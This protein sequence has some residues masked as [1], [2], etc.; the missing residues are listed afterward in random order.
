MVAISVFAQRLAVAQSTASIF[1]AGNV[2]NWGDPSI[3]KAVHQV[4]RAR[5]FQRGN[6]SAR[7]M[8]VQQASMEGHLD[9]A[10]LERDR[11]VRDLRFAATQNLT[12]VVGDFLSTHP[13]PNTV[14]EM[15]AQLPSFPFE[16][17]GRIEDLERVE[18]IAEMQAAPQTA[19]PD[20]LVFRA[21]DALFKRKVLLKVPKERFDRS[22]LTVDPPN[23]MS[24]LREAQILG[25]TN[26]DLL[27]FISPFLGV[28][29]MDPQSEGFREL[30]GSQGTVVT[31]SG[32]LEGRTFSDVYSMYPEPLPSIA[33]ILS[34]FVALANVVED[35]HKA[36][37]LHGRLLPQHVL[38]QE[39]GGK[40]DRIALLNL[41]QAMVIAPK[42]REGLFWEILYSKHDKSLLAPEV[43]YWDPRT[44]PRITFATDVYSLGAMLALMTPGLY[45]QQGPKVE[46]LGRPNPE[47]R[48]L[49]EA[50]TPIVL[51]ATQNNPEDRYPTAAAM[52]EDL[53]RLQ[54]RT[55]SGGIPQ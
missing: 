12:A 33:T 53:V 25:H 7:S 49:L 17:F 29:Y 34:W 42:T 39:L 45:L 27:P 31:V 28:Y 16:R 19:D 4:E 1:A 37:F 14:R 36:G 6:M 8:A 35:L 21:T 20:T 30:F 26:V 32:L 5:L 40:E 22:S 44:Q 15:I 50:I 46:I 43:I 9:A 51:R 47:E 10:R 48:S 55:S 52:R 3:D 41:E 23:P 2:G 11:M 54:E 38:L 13:D 24:V 18:G